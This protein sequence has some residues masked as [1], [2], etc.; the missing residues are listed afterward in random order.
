MDAG[1]LGFADLLRARVCPDFHNS[2]WTTLVVDE[3]RLAPAIVTIVSL[4][5][6]LDIGIAGIVDIND[7]HHYLQGNI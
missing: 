4:L 3:T 2:S 7:V 6:K 1:L 5:W